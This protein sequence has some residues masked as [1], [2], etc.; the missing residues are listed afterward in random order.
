MC[1]N[2]IPSTSWNPAE[3]KAIPVQR[4]I[5]SR[6]LTSPTLS[7]PHEQEH[8][9]EHSQQ[10]QHTKQKNTNR[11]RKNETSKPNTN[12]RESEP[13]QT[14]EDTPV[15]S[16]LEMEQQEYHRS[17]STYIPRRRSSSSNTTVPA[18]D[19]IPSHRPACPSDSNS[20]QLILSMHVASSNPEKAVFARAV[21]VRPFDDR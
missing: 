14:R 21:A 3:T 18:E 5:P 4:C 12:H 2:E 16:L 19:I 13:K 7:T 10:N 1:T 20:L 11:R 6:P 8:E 15:L 17:R 9:Q